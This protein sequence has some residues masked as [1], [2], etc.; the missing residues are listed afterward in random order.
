MPIVLDLCAG[1]PER[2][3]APGEVLLKEGDSTKKELFILAEGCLEVVKGEEISITMI[4]EPGSA[5]GE[6]SVLLGIPFSA[7]VRAVE[8]TRCFVAADGEAFLHAHPEATFAVAKL[9]ARRLH[10]ATT[11]LADI[12]R[13]Y[14]DHDAS[15]AMVDQVLETFVHHHEDENQD[16]EP[17][18]DREREPNY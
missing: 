10:L 8:P 13:Q 2:Q 12:K 3:L 5:I 4:T 1:L 6:I 15:L 18:S 9:L 14:E 7:S 16:V 11:Y 17:G